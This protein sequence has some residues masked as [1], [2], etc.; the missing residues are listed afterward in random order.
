MIKEKGFTLIELIM[1]IAILGI[2]AA[3]AIPQYVDL[4]SSAA[5]A[6]TDGVAGALGSAAA[7][8]YAA[9]EAG[10]SCTTV[11]D[12]TGVGAL[13]ASG[14]VPT[15]Y[16]IDS[17]AIADGASASCTLNGEESTTATFTGYGTTAP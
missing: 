3:I 2:L 13:L 14:A 11:S 5:Q 7:I 8:N 9:C 1:V 10:S 6:A 16:S 17:T 4:K 12:C 15:G